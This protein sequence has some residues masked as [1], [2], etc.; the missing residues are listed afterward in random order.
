MF[1]TQI[2]FH[3]TLKAFNLFSVQNENKYWTLR[4]FCEIWN[5]GFLRILFHTLNIFQ[6]KFSS[7]CSCNTKFFTIQRVKKR[8]YAI[9]KPYLRLW[10][11]EEVKDTHCIGWVLCLGIK[12]NFT[13]E[14]EVLG[15]YFQKK[16]ALS[17]IL[18]LIYF[19]HRI[20]LLKLRTWALCTANEER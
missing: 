6:G 10:N 13:K 19:K 5:V 3:K 2:Y 7:G 11:R 17:E 16:N 20:C 18:A 15:I 14:R 1:L 4:S 12:I 9:F 8:S